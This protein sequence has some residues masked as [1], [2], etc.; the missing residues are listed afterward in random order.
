MWVGTKEK[1]SQ[2]MSN[3]PPL[4]SKTIGLEVCSKH[5][6]INRNLDKDMAN[7]EM[8]QVNVVKETQPISLN[9]KIVSLSLVLSIMH[10]KIEKA[11]W[12]RGFSI[13]SKQASPKRGVESL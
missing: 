7:A 5:R 12:F 6:L 2:D 10:R 11:C 13:S 8:D 3:S 1:G 9:P 4:W